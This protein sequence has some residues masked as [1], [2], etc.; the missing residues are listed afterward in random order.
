MKDEEKLPSRKRA[1]TSLEKEKREKQ[2]LSKMK[3]SVME[4]TIKNKK[5]EILSLK[6]GMKEKYVYKAVKHM[7]KATSLAVSFLPFCIVHNPS[8]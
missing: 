1:N 7:S 2:K 6:A 8:V 5:L 4:N 3:K